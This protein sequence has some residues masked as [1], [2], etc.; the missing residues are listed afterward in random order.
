ML[1]WGANQTS[2]LMEPDSAWLGINPWAILHWKAVK[3]NEP[4]FT[5]QGFCNWKYLFH[6]STYFMACNRKIT[7]FDNSMMPTCI[8]FW[9]QLDSRNVQQRYHHNYNCRSSCAGFNHSRGN[10]TLA[11]EYCSS[12]LRESSKRL[13]SG[14]TCSA[15]HILPSNI[16]IH[17]LA[18]HWA[19]P[20]LLPRG[21]Q[22]C[23]T[24]FSQTLSRK[25]CNNF[26]SL[27]KASP[28]PYL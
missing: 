20:S 17:Q 9:L 19:Q 25:E 7:I 4:A 5:F 2:I 8:S 26:G 1:I 18:M 15:P 12:W 21:R 13:C 3:N 6:G 24:R 11:G 16:M 23:S 10:F 22:I 28:S 14:N 27:G